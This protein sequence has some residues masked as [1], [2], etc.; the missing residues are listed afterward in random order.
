LIADQ[1]VAA[2]TFHTGTTN[3]GW[4]LVNPDHPFSTYQV[5]AITNEVAP[6]G[7]TPKGQILLKGDL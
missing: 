6:G 7:D 1:P 5:S 4:L 2:G 3:V